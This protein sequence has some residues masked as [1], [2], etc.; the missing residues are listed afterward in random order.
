[1]GDGDDRGDGEVADRDPERL[2]HADDPDA[3]GR[4]IEPD[5]LGRL[6]QRGRR[7]VDVV[8]LGLAAREADLAR[9]VTAVGRTLDEDDPGDAVVIG[10]QQGEDPG[11]PG[12][13]PRTAGRRHPLRQRLGGADHH[14]HQHLGRRRQG[15]GQDRQ[16]LEGVGEPHRVAPAAS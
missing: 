9:V 16:S 5:L 8:G 11:G 12:R 10:I 13:A 15:I 14:R 7:D 2:E 4:G 1:M 6:A 3:G